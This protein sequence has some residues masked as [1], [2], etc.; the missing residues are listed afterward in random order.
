M[1]SFPEA[2][3]YPDV[4]VARQ[5]AEVYARQIHPFG[6]ARAV[7]QTWVRDWKC[8]CRFVVR[9]HYK[10]PTQVSDSVFRG[11]ETQT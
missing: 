7:R 1:H 5:A 9:G 6:S 11:C 2:I 3:Y 8:E 10:F 4:D